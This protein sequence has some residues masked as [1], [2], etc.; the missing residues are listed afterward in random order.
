M[1]LKGSRDKFEY[2][3]GVETFSTKSASW[4][5]TSATSDLLQ[6]GC[7]LIPGMRH[8][9]AINPCAVLLPK[10]SRGVERCL[11]SN[12]RPCWLIT[13]RTPVSGV[14]KRFKL[15]RH[16]DLQLTFRLRLHKWKSAFCLHGSMVHAMHT[17]M[18]LKAS[19]NW[20]FLLFLVKYIL[21][22]GIGSRVEHLSS[23]CEIPGLI[24]PTK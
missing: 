22:G 17:C 23:M 9:G 8:S 19:K 1:S 20:A 6:T 16:K 11:L 14:K 4:I 18:F 12:R 7:C 13:Q 2:F 10:F 3:S 15:I 24:P 5:T 21:A